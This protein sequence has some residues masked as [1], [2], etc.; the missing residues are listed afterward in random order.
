MNQK[1]QHDKQREIF[2]RQILEDIGSSAQIDIHKIDNWMQSYLNRIFQTLREASINSSGKLFDIGCGAFGWVP[3]TASKNGYSMA[4][5]VEISPL[6]CQYAAAFS[7]KALLKNMP[8][9]MQ[10]SAEDLCFKNETFD[11]VTCIA[12]LEHVTDDEAVVN[13]MARVVKRNGIVYI[14]VPN[15][16]KRI[17][18]FLRWY[19]KRV[20]KKMGHLRHYSRELLL[21]KLRRSGF[22]DIRFYTSGHFIKMFQYLLTII[23]P[24]LNSPESRLWWFLER[25]DLKNVENDHG[26]TLTAIAR[27]Q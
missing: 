5:G 2:D 3:I 27:R 1:S 7:K 9:Y 12:L 6:S 24:V 11:A 18:F 23:F 25:L 4:C 14:V 15:N 20:D 22:G 26:V 10:C 8:Y 17:P 13:E 16:Y 19:Y 21:E